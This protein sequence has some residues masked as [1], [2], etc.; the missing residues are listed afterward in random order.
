MTRL[1]ALACAAVAACR[2]SLPGKPACRIAS[3][4]SASQPVSHGHSGASSP[5]ASAAPMAAV[6]RPRTLTTAAGPGPREPCVSRSSSTK[7]WKTPARST[8]KPMAS[9]A[10][11]P[12]SPCPSSQTAKTAVVPEA[13]PRPSQA[14][15]CTRASQHADA[16]SSASRSGSG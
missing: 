13:A 4:A 14:R 8:H 15:P 11:R 6:K 10:S 5:F 3:A 16:E 12:S 2:G 9:Q 7:T 1:R